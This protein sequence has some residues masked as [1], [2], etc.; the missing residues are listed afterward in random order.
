MRWTLLNLQASA[1]FRIRTGAKTSWSS[2]SPL[3]LVHHFEMQLSQV[4]SN[5]PSSNSIERDGILT[6]AWVG[7]LAFAS[8]TKHVSLPVVLFW[9]SA[10]PLWDAVEASSFR[11]FHLLSFFEPYWMALTWR[12]NFE[13][14]KVNSTV[15]AGK[16]VPDFPILWIEPYWD[17][18]TT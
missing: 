13:T 4:L 1:T 15:D 12:N 17:G 16:F 8:W 9:W 14:Q 11:T 10:S 6:C 2:S 3:L 7:Q 18:L 5:L